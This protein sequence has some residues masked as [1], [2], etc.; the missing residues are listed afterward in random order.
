[1]TNPFG[2]YPSK[3]IE[4]R[5]AE[6]NKTPRGTTKEILGWV[7]EDLERAQRALDQENAEEKPRKTVVKAL[8]DLL[9]D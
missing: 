9:N 8:E 1:M 5:A 6:A 7:G 4:K 2:N 3:N